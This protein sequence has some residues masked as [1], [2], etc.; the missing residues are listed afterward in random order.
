MKSAK[1]T[2]N[3]A[4]VTIP[5]FCAMRALA[6]PEEVAED[7]LEEVLLPC[8]DVGVGVEVK[9]LV[10]VEFLPPD[11]VEFEPA[12]EPELPVPAAATEERVGET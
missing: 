11:R 3:P 8:A 1:A 7:E 5:P 12:R 9:L 2:P 6:A 10:E 4:R